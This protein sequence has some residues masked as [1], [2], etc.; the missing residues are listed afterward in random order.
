MELFTSGD[1]S[2]MDVIKQWIDESD[3]YLLILG[4]RYGSIE[5]KS[6]KSY[7][8][9]EYEYSSAKRNRFFPASSK[10]PR[11]RFE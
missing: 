6:G 8:Q 5:P 9:L 4:G 2:Q 1:E 7:T 10:T 11:L 3:V